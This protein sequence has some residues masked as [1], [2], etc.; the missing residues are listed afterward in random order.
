MVKKLNTSTREKKQAPN[1]VRKYTIIDEYLCLF[2]F[3]KKPISEGFIHKLCEEFCKWANRDGKDG[4]D[5]SLRLDDFADEMGVNKRDIERWRLKFPNLQEAYEYAK[6]RIA[7]RREIGA[8]KRRYESSTVL[9]TQGYYCDVYR[10]EE[11]RRAKLQKDEERPASSFHVYLDG[12][13]V[14]EDK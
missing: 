14:T 12:Q 2:S 5:E 4:S 13:R 1:V 10:T 11:E 3:K 6:R 9:K 7:S 8:M